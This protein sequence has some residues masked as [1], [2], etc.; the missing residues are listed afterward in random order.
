MSTLIRPELTVKNRYWIER[1]RYYELKHFCLQYPIWKK[2]YEALDSLS[3]RPDDLSIF[4]KTNAV[5]DP[6]SKCAEARLAYS[7]K[8]LL[9]EQAA[10]DTDIELCG[11]ILTAV[12]EGL[13]Y[14]QLKAQFDIPCCKDVYYVLYRKF[15]WVLNKTRL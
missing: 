5:N 13:S 11:Y 12:T 8:M 1:H 3:Q 2:A 4:S 7:A 6:V 14:N 15:F 9:V 10:K